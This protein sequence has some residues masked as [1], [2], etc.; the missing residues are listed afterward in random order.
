MLFC[1]HAMGADRKFQVQFVDEFL[2]PVDMGTSVSIYIY[3][4][5][6]TTEITTYLDKLEQNTVTTPITD[7][8]TNTSLAYERGFMQW[9][10]KPAAFKLSVTDGTSSR[11]FDNLT[12]SNVAIMWPSFLV[13]LS[14]SSYGA[15]DNI[16]FTFAG[17]VI[18]G[19]VAGTLQFTPDADDSAVNMG[20]TDATTDFNLYGGTSGRNLYWDASENT[21]E[22]LDNTV[23]A[24]GTGD[25]WTASHDGSTT[26]LAGAATITGV[27]TYSDDVVFDGTYDIKYDDSRYQLHFQDDAV[28]GI[29]GAADAVGDVTMTHDGSDFYLDAAIADEGF[30]IG[31]VTSGFDLT[32]YFETAGQIRTDYDADFLN[33]TD[34][35]ELR[36]GTGASSNGDIA[37]SSNSTNILQFEQ[38]VSDT[39]TITYGATGAGM[40]STWYGEEAGD[41]MKW[42]GTGASQLQ[43]VGAD[44]SGTLV[45]ITGIDTTGNTDTMTIAHKGTGDGLQI[46][47]SEADSVAL[48]LVAAT[49]QTT[50]LAK[51]DGSTGSWL[52]A[53]N[54]GMINVTN[55]G[56]L[57]NVASSLMYIANT[58]VPT[59]DSRGSSLRIVDTGDAAA[60]TAGY[61]VYVSATDATVEALMIDDGDVLIDES[62]DVG[63]VIT[64]DG[65]N[66]SVVVVTT[67]S[68]SVLA[69]NTGMIHVINDLAG[70]TTLTLPTEAT[71]LNYEFWYTG[72][73]D[74]AHNHIIVATANTNY[75]IG[76]VQFG[77]TDA[78]PGAAELLAVYGNGSTEGKLTLNVAEAGTIIR[79]SCDGTNWYLN[80]IVF[81]I[82]AP[83]F[84]VVT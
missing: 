62:L 15:G 40:D 38:V 63:G 11:N 60:G 6:T 83:T 78:G 34:D 1:S 75:F 77:D 72:G 25:D 73:V 55:D 9:Y 43:L 47:A 82:T 69:A 24:V 44:S 65:L 64:T 61:A 59:N 27:Q 8:S 17:H 52:G 37:I 84:A 68:Y 19:A 81:A 80:G 74:E 67:G 4:V 71:G 56:A 12:G 41:Y 46:T 58:G 50:S 22:V 54:V 10:Q 26:T 51:F 53:A 30:K 57:A 76:G 32:Y 45:A 31:D 18:S 66:A 21:L 5:G 39:G 35:M 28:L 48:N 79:I 14:S 16:D 49:S 2:R 7:D 29:G 20:T 70:A 36:F 23:I 42:D 3:A 13:E 33:L